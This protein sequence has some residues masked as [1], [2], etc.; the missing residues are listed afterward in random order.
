MSSLLFTMTN[1]DSSVPPTPDAITS[2]LLDA[3]SDDVIEFLLLN[4]V[5][6]VLQH[7]PDTAEGLPIA[8]QAHYLAFILDCEVLNGGFNQLFF[9]HPEMAGDASQAFQ[10][11]GMDQVAALV[12][13]TSELYQEV[14]SRHEAAKSA[15]TVEAFAKTYEGSPFDEL[16][17]LYWEQQDEWRLERIKYIRANPNLFL[18]P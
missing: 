5:L 12:T 14:R 2:D 9:N 4:Y 6:D 3:T 16:D 11:L 18:H 1:F 13:K 15:G 17:S 10:Y 8:L 7:R